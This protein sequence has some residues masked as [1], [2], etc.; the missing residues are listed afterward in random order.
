MNM[1]DSLKEQLTLPLVGRLG[2][3]LG[4]KAVQS[5]P[6]ADEVLP[7]Q[8]GALDRM[9][10]TPQGAQQLLDLARDR[11]PSGTVDQLTSSADGLAK[12]QQAGATLLPEVMGTALPA[13]VTRVATATRASEADVHRMMERL[14]PLL[15]GLIAGHASRQKLTAATL[16]TLFTGAALAGGTAAVL[17]STPDVVIEQGAPV[18]PAPVTRSA[19]PVQRVQEESRRRGLG[20]L[21]LLPLLLLV[22]LGGCFLLRGK[23]VA[24]LTLTTPVSAAQVDAGGPLTFTGSGRAGETVTVSENGTALTT[25]KVNSDGGYTATVPSPAAG[26]HSY[27][28]SETGTDITLN[29]AVTVA[30]VAAVPA[31]PPVA[32]PAPAASTTLAVTAPASNSTVAAGAL[33]LKGTGPASTNLDITE[34]GIS[35]GQTKTDASG[36]WTFQVPGPATGKHTYLATAGTASSS[37][38]LTVAVATAQ[39]GPCIKPFSLSLKTGQTVKQPFRFG[40]VGSGK[41]YTVTVS[42]GT[43]KIGSKVLPLDRSCSYSYTSKPGVGRVTYTL[44][45]DGQTTVASK[46]TLKVTR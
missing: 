14:L 39:A 4:L 24:G 29:R 18:R 44:K 32:T 26:T 45:E 2:A 10:R 36:A 15:L 27:T 28:V 22:L 40:G 33:T 7:A 25:T 16:S 43:R 23:G 19:P 12:L 35:L 1:Q 11:V 3:S 30:A 9:A 17:S 6:I 41:S 8:L 42:R 46:I 38:D 31:T 37:L 13:E 20:W 21:W 34:D 5:A